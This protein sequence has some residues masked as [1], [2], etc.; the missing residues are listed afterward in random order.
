MNNDAEYQGNRTAGMLRGMEGLVPMNLK[1]TGSEEL[2]PIILY[3][4]ELEGMESVWPRLEERFRRTGHSRPI[5]FREYDSYKELPG[6]DGDLYTYDAVVLSALV[7][8]GFLRAL[9][10]A[11]TYDHVFPW[12]MDKTRVRQRNYGVPFM[13]CSNALICRQKEDLHARNI[14][15]LHENVAIPM[16]SMLMF[17]FVQAVIENQSLKKSFHVMEHLLD[18]IGG[19][20]SLAAS[21][22]GDYDGIN[23]FNREECRYLLSFTEDLADLKKDDYAVYFANFSDNETRKRPLFLADFI[24]VGKHIQKEKLQ[25]CLDL[26]QILISEQFVYE[27]CVP[28]GR[29]EYLLPADRHVFQRLAEYDSLY[30]SLYSQVDSEENGILRYGKRFYEDFYTKR[31]LLLQLL[32]ERAGWK[33]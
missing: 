21:G 5:L 23:R 26:I 2:S 22:M 30:K 9:P 20:D 17:Y 3:Y 14:M 13:L 24:S 1:K 7:D 27:T 11:V 4:D 16:R 10:K 32:W 29:L 31:D 28:D 12:I 33:P 6:T 15:E 8:K 18:L 25:D 19:R